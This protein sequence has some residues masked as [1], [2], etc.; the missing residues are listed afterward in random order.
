MLCLKTIR[1]RKTVFAAPA[2]FAVVT[3]ITI[4]VCG[5]FAPEIQT[6]ICLTVSILASGWMAGLWIRE[7]RKS[8]AAQL[9]I[10]NQIMHIRS[11]VISDGAGEA[12]EAE[13]ADNIDVFVSYFGILV[14]S[15]IIKFNQ[16]GIS[17]KAVEIGPEFISL[18]YG[19][20]KQ[21][22]NTLLFWGGINSGEL[23]KIVE[24]FRY[25]TGVVPVI[26]NQL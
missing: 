7:H 6:R 2:G 19:R 20:E 25:E 12:E 18:T 13:D 21:V 23:E 16:D 4:L 8:E 26:I 24:R 15:K 17:L 5:I 11:A 9:I 14:G 22:Q 10:E 3:S 1:R